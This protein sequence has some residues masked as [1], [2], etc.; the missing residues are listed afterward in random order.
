[1]R[2]RSNGYSLGTVAKSLTLAPRQTRRIQK[3]EW[4][5]SE[6]S[7]RQ[8]TTRLSDRVS[9]TLSRERDYDDSVQ[10]NLEW[11][12]GQSESS[13]SSGAVGFGFAG[14][15]FVLGGGGASSNAES[16]SSQEG[17]RR[18]TAA[19]EQRLQDSIRRYGDSLRKL[20]SMVVTTRTSWSPQDYEMFH[21]YNFDW[22][23]LMH[24]FKGIEVLSVRM[25]YENCI[26]KWQKQ[27]EVF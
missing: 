2:W 9:D 26:F 21:Y 4:R 11:A 8:E 24:L 15:G 10:A 22:L 20:D 23:L 19:E 13:S 18:T 14:T 16:E 12:R 7:S 17:G 25:G 1:M 27:N 3:I 5:R 6:L